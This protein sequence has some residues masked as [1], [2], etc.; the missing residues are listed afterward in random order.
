MEFRFSWQE[1]KSFDDRAVQRILR[2]VDNHEL[3]L[4]LYG[5]NGEARDKILGNKL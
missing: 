4:S 3:A 1:M 5:L 2:E